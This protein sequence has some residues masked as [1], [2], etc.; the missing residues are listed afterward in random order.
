MKINR[1]LLML[2]VALSLLLGGCT[3]EKRPDV[4]NEVVIMV[5]GSGSY[6]ARRL[7]AITSAVKLLESIAETKVRRWEQSV[8]RI[9]IIAVDAVPEV[10][11]QGSVR[12]LKALKSTDWTERFKARTDYENCT[13]EEAAFKLAVKSLQGDSQYVK[14]YLLAYTD[15]ISEPPTSSIRR[16]Q[17]PAKPSVPSEDFPWT[18]LQDVSVSI[19]WVPPEQKLAW[20]RIVAEHGLGSSFALYTTSESSE[21]KI[22]APTKATVKATEADRAADRESY[23]QTIFTVLEW[24]GIILMALVAII[25]V[26]LFIVRTI[27]G[28]RRRISRGTTSRPVVRPLPISQM[29][30]IGNGRA[31]GQGRRP[32]P[33]R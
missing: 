21:V 1:T 19:F 14:K 32:A 26:S 2:V 31:Q 13:D 33:N 11:W 10:I 23:K 27:G 25:G 12:E 3:S 24:L 7:E 28:R 29:R 6:K 8:D 4:F 22:S 17:P 16:C 5:D 9:T 15:L 30:A 20:K 18:D